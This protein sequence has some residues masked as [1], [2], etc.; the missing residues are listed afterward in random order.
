MK[1]KI[2]ENLNDMIKVSVLATMLA[3]P[4]YLQAEKIEKTLKTNTPYK[5]YIELV[6][7][8]DTKKYKKG[9]TESQIIN[10]VA[11]TLFAEGKGEGQKGISYIASVIYNRAG[12]H[13]ENLAPE[14]LKPLAFSCWNGMES[15]DKK[16]KNFKI[17]LPGKFKPENQAIWEYCVETATQMFN[18]DYI[19]I[20]KALTHYYNPKKAKPDWHDKLQNV[21]VIG[22]H[23]FGYLDDEDGY[24]D[25]DNK[26]AFNVKKTSKQNTDSSKKSKEIIYKIKNGDTIG[27]IAKQYKVKVEDIKKK[28]PTL[29]NLD[30]IKVGQKI[31]I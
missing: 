25:Y 2:N 21:I 19:P 27:K 20:D 9:Y 26:P 29:K 8:T 16:A 22:N 12:G 3:I 4:G 17:K 15:K 7:K 1:T 31:K 24:L 28:N 10:I 14:A 11:R 23:R 6:N 30:K 5:S 13:R 18:E